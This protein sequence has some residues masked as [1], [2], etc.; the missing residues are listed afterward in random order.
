MILEV[1]NGYF[2]YSGEKEILSDI[3]LEI[4]EGKALA[5]LDPN[6]VGKTTLLKCM[7]GLL[8][9]RTGHT[10]LYGKDIKGKKPKEIWS[11]ISYIPQARSFAFS[12]TGMEMVLIGRSVHMGTFA[13]PG[14][15]ELEMAEDIMERVGI[16]HLAKKSCNQMSGGELQLVLIARALISEPKCIILDE[17]E[18]GLDFHNQIVVLNM[19][20]KLVH[21]EGI[22]AVMNTHYPTNALSV[23]DHAFLM[24]RSGSY[25]FG[26][27]QEILTEKNI[28]EAFQVDVVV[29]EVLHK[30]KTVRSI[31][32]VALL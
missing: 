7:T 9:W 23:S 17:P 22:S 25:Y 26:D 3:N 24:T 12:Y 30:G 16:V 15:K 28:M 13:Q 19:I 20:D 18:T 31:V 14:K 11:V 8:E 21:D 32:P 6:G 29:S 27:T 2:G 1:K 10:F 5:I 4:S